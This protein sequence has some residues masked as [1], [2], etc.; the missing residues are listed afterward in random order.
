[1]I[2]SKE[3]WG[4]LCKTPEEKEL[5]VKLLDKITI[6]QRRG[7]PQ[8]TD[9]LDPHL[10]EFAVR[11]LEQIPEILW[12]TQGTSPLAERCRILMY[13]DGAAFELQGDDSSHEGYVCLLKCEGSFSGTKVTHRDFLGAFLGTGIKREK[14]GDIWVLEDGCAVAAAAELAGYLE[15]Q[16]IR[17]RGVPLS[18]RKIEPGQLVTPRQ[19][20]KIITT[21]VSSLRLDAIAAAGFS[22]SRAKLSKEI[23]AGKLKVNWQDTTKLDFGLKE[24]D[25]LS[26]R[27]RGRVILRE[28]AGESKKGRIK[29]TLERLL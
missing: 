25:V 7:L 18:I 15:Q 27:G 20:G 8:A 16:D 5:A 22:T 3:E 26:V 28:V 29:I 9:F 11:I 12:E 17:V 1:M 23:S 24:G 13:Q 19:E 2:R 21:T 4:R 6:V 10:Q 14:L